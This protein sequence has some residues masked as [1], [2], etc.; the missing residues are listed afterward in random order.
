MSFDPENGYVADG[1]FHLIE[2]GET[3]RVLEAAI[4]ESLV[5]LWR[6]YVLADEAGLSEDA[7]DLRRDLMAR[8][9]T[10]P[11]AA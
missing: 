6:E 11:D 2:T 10:T 7:R 1:P 4:Q 8:F 9:G 3:R 5:F